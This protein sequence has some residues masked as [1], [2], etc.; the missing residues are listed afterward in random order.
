M[1]ARLLREAGLDLGPDDELMPASEGNSEGHWENLRFVEINDALLERAGGFWASIPPLEDGWQFDPKFDDLLERG[2]ALVA[3]FAGREPWGW[4]DPRNSLTLPFWQRLMPDLKVVVAVRH[5]FEVANSLAAR[6]RFPILLSVEL[7]T[8]YN[9]RVMK[10]A[11]AEKR[12]VTHYESYFLSFT[13]ETKRLLSFVGLPADADALGRLCHLAKDDLRHNR[14]PLRHSLIGQMPQAAMRLYLASCAES[15]DVFLRR[16]AAEVIAN[17]TT[18]AERLNDE[19]AKV[20]YLVDATL[21]IAEQDLAAA[22]LRRQIDERDAAL[23]LSREQTAA[24]WRK[25]E[26][27]RTRLSWKRHRWMDQ[28]ANSLARLRGR[29]PEDFDDEEQSPLGG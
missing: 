4:K 17:G 28:I 9:V 18:P 15:G 16:L 20:H 24:A 5:P 2:A 22:E 12:L 21:R 23:A 14:H 6:D 1:I 10:H 27:L 8:G 25:I 29:E 11:L 3:R 13:N 19:E 7:W 26:T